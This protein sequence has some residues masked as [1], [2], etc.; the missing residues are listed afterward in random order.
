[1]LAIEGQKDT[2]VDKLMLAIIYTRNEK[3]SREEWES[4]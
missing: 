1:M 3:S 4:I 2:R